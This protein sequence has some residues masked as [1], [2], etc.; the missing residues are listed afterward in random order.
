MTE[1]RIPLRGPFLPGAEQTPRY[2]RMHRGIFSPAEL[3]IR[4]EEVHLGQLITKSRRFLQGVLGG[5]FAISYHLYAQMSGVDWKSSWLS[6]S[7]A[8]P[9]EAARLIQGLQNPSE[10]DLAFSELDPPTLLLGDSWYE[11]VRQPNVLLTAYH[12]GWDRINAL[13]CRYERNPA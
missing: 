2:H 6:F 10:A 1:N 13:V 12:L 8:R 11:V 9:E 5:Q 3:K 4:L 7:K